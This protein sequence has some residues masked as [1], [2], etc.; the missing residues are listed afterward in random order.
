MLA[1][2][3]G[4]NLG[5]ESDQQ[6]YSTVEV[7]EE[8]QRFASVKPVFRGE[9][10][11]YGITIPENAPHPPEAALFLAFLLGSQ[12]RAIMEADHHPMFEHALCDGYT[13]TPASLQF[14]CVLEEVP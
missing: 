4:I 12:G 8:S 11:G 13:S 6:N 7:N 2:P 14:L 1:L 3:D 9:R 10:I 5:E